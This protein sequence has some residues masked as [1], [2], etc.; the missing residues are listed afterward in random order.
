MVRLAPSILI[1]AIDQVIVFIYLQ[2]NSKAGYCQSDRQQT[3]NHIYTHKEE[4][5]KP[6]LPRCNEAKPD[7]HLSNWLVPV[8]MN[9]KGLRMQC[10]PMTFEHNHQ[11]FSMG[12]LQNLHSSLNG[13][14]NSMSQSN[15]IKRETETLHRI[16]NQIILQRLL[17]C[18]R[19]SIANQ[20]RD[21]VICS[22]RTWL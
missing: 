11:R 14:G 5:S 18:N 17:G 16:N 7:L 21:C 4:E 19:I 13:V 6:I 20:S 1:E 22:F 15:R 12:Y 8:T 2:S 9:A 3:L 10:Y